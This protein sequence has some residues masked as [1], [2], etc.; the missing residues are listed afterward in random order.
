[1]TQIHHGNP[2]DDELRETAADGSVFAC[3]F[4]LKGSGVVV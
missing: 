4:T 1:M 2:D 3:P